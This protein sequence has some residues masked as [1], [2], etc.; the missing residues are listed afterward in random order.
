MYSI[1]VFISL[2]HKNFITKTVQAYKRHHHI[3]YI[4]D[5]NDHSSMNSKSYRADS[6]ENKKKQKNM[7]HV[8]I[9][10]NVDT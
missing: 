10:N 3:V 2:R 7:Q 1:H 4:H 6:P 9:H 5:S 8:Q